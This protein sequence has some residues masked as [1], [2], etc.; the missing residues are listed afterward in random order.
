LQR[1]TLSTCI[2]S[3]NQ[4]TLLKR[5]EHLE[6]IKTYFNFSERPTLEIS[7]ET[8]AALNSGLDAAYKER[9]GEVIHEWLLEGLAWGLRKA[10]TE[11]WHKSPASRDAFGQAWSTKK[12][13][14]T[15]DL[16]SDQYHKVILKDGVLVIQTNPANAGTNCGDTGSSPSVLETCDVKFNGISYRYQFNFD[17]GA[18]DI[19]KT[20]LESMSTALG[21]PITYEVKWDVL[22]PTLI[23]SE[24][25][26]TSGDEWN[27]R[28]P[29]WFA[30][31]LEGLAYKISQKAADEMVK[32]AL[33][34]KWK[35]GVVKVQYDD[36]IPKRLGKLHNAVEFLNG[37]LVIKF[38]SQSNTGDVGQDIEERL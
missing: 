13:H 16:P 11:G 37:D 32:E 27:W 19:I 29:D 8:W 3:Y 28:A 14:L 23:K 15:L 21:K 1:Q 4:H 9:P 31:A 5:D 26:A 7:N 35:S 20:S 25:H 33:L 6:A 17:N 18:C 2:I 34:D 12:I 38:A 24:P 36:S 10:F 22:G 30:S